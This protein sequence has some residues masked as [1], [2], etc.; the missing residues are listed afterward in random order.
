[1]GRVITAALNNLKD[2][3]NKNRIFN[4]SN[5]YLLGMLLMVIGL[6]FSVFLMS[7]SLFILSGNW[8]LE[9]NYKE[10][11]YRFAKN[12][13]A[14]LITSVFLLHIIGLIYT[15]DFQYALKD[16][17]IKSPLLILAFILG[18]IEF[19]DK[20]KINYVLFTFCLAIIF[21]SLFCVF[22]FA[23]KP[24][25][26]LRDIFVFVSHI[27]YGLLIDVAIFIF[28]YYT[29]RKNHFKLIH[30]LFFLF[31]AIWLFIF[32][33]IAQLFTGFIIFVFALFL[34]LIIYFIIYKKWI[35]KFI[36]LILFVTLIYTLV[37]KV[38][39][40][41]KEFE[42]K[43][44]FDY[45]TLTDTT[46]RGNK[47]TFD[48][49][50]QQ[51]ENGNYVWSFICEKEMESAWNK[52]SKIKFRDLDLKGQTINNTIIRFLSSLNYRKDSVGVNKLTDEQV[53]AIESG[54][55]N[56]K[57]MNK[58]GV[59]ARYNQTL[60][61]VALY[62]DTK[63]PNG[64]S[65]VQR[66]EYWKTAISIIQKNILIG[67]GTGDVNQAFKTAYFKNHSRL[68]IEF[69]KRA[70][71]Q[72]LEFAVTFGIIGLIWF[73]IALFYPVF[74]LKKFDFLYIAFFIIS[75]LSMLTEDTLET[76]AGICFFA[77]F[78]TFFLFCRQKNIDK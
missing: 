67:V 56:W 20:K 45:E 64:S 39:K 72:F 3:F 31:A 57:F 23:N 8:F 65:L 63:N 66:Y 6:P 70:H 78:T 19:Y 76:Q 5:V 61:E 33:M 35:Y 59:L 55:V 13:A 18:S 15:N 29:F 26:D 16:L 43:N 22:K 42:V 4:H 51:Y 9:G 36:P 11:I 49:L 21:S 41:Y 14:V 24:V 74:I 52:R 7:I 40:D 38:G 77:F 32:L 1:M 62:L 30:K 25:A 10:K 2:F 58:Y 73:L 60:A 17:R 47:Y 44:Y 37:L 53:N 12:K 48:M 54:V 71:N 46:V 27:R 69:R 28:L 68:D 75:F 34:V 50:N